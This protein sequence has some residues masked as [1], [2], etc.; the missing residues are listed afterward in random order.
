MNRSNQFKASLIRS[1]SGFLSRLNTLIRGG[2]LDADF[3][4]QLEEVL[5]SGDVGT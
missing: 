1:K 2:E 3:Y 5:I 4:D